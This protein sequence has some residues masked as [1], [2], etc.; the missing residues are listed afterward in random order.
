M[1]ERNLMIGLDLGGTSMMAVA[2]SHQGGMIAARRRSTRPSLGP[3]GV[4]A[5][6]ALSLIHI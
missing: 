5:R 1:G 2:L 6:V 4:T 3:D